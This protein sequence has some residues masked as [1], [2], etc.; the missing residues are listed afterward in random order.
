VADAMSKQAK[1]SEP[2]G[3]RRPPKSGQFKKGQSGNP[4][5][6]PKRSGPIDIDFD[7]HLEEVFDVK[8][9]GRQEIELNR[10]LMKAMD[11]NKP[12]FKSIAY[13]LDLFEKYDCISRPVQSSGGVLTM[14]TNQY[15]FR[16]CTLIAE[17]YGLPETWTKAQ[18]AWGRKQYEATKTDRERL[19]ES[20]GVFN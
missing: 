19:E 6:R 11:K 10:V 15:P 2:A 18:I 5:G 3:Y 8:V 12:D 4:G 13:L 16:M 20:V 1:D 7:Q 9:N 14:P 17:R